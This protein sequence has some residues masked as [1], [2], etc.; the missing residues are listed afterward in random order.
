[1]FYV[2]NT[3]DN[4]GFHEIKDEQGNII[5]TAA[6]TDDQTITTLEVMGHTDP[7]IETVYDQTAWNNIGH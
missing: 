5:A 2:N 3:P 4:E 7:T 1:M 6:N